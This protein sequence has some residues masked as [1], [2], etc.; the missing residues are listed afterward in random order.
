MEQFVPNV[1]DPQTSTALKRL[2]TYSLC[3]VLLPLITMF[4]LRKLVFESEAAPL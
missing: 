1:S 3:V 4:A 2:V